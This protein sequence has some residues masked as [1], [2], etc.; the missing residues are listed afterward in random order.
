MK[1]ISIYTLNSLEA[2]SPY[3]A[4]T[5]FVRNVDGYDVKFIDTLPTR[6]FRLYMDK[7]PKKKLGRI[8]FR[9]MFYLSQ[10]LIGSL[11]LMN[12]LFFRKPDV[13]VV[14]REIFVDRFPSFMM[15]V[16]KKLVSSRHLVWSFDD[17]IFKAGEISEKEKQLLLANTERVVVPNDFLKSLLPENLQAVTSVVHPTDGDILP[18]LHIDQ[19]PMLKDIYDKEIR[20][21]W[22]GTAY[23]MQYVANIAPALNKAAKKLKEEYGKDTLLYI[24]SN[25]GLHVETDYLKIENIPWK[26]DVAVRMLGEAHIGIMP[27]NNSEYSIAKSGCKLVQYLTAGLPCIGSAVGYNKKI[28]VDSGYGY[29]L[30]DSAGTDVWEDAV[31]AL[32]IDKN[33]WISASDRAFQMS[34]E[35]FSYSEDLE[36]WKNSL[37]F[38]DAKTKI[39]R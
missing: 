3:Y 13:V 31:L 30:D 35:Q 10:W 26:R 28:I 39:R 36:I 23:S 20:I 27:L 11:M 33:F 8:M 2:G 38:D 6:L 19:R 29:L 12:D 7:M 32:S 18:E 17:H 37:K 21:I 14:C 5:Q 22:I 15:P 16:Y 25:A 1:K 4:V 34:Q 9:L 24:V